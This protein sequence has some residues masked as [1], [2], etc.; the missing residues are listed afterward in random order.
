[1][2]LFA[3]LLLIVCLTVAVCA[4]GVIPGAVWR[5]LLSPLGGAALLVFALVRV[6][7]A[8]GELARDRGRE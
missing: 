6:L 8:M 7:A 1:M 2:I 5:A 4:L 3:A